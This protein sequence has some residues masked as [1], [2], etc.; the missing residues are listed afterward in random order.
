[1]GKLGI[2]QGFRH[3][4]ISRGRNA[5]LIERGKAF[6]VDNVRDQVSMRP[7]DPSSFRAVGVIWPKR[8]SLI[9][10]G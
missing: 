2:G 7:S 6:A 5:I 8:G 10:C 1:M 3:G 9:H 4:T